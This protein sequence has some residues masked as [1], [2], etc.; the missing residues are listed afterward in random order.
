MRSHAALAALLLALPGCAHLG[1]KPVP[2][3]EAGPTG[4]DPLARTALERG[5]SSLDVSTRMRSL[6][7]LLRCVPTA[8]LQGLALRAFYDPSA[9]VRRRAVEALGARRPEPETTALL[10]TALARPELG[11]ATRARA[12]ELLLERGQPDLSAQLSAAWRALPR[13]WESVPLALVALRA[14]DAEAEA[15]VAAALREGLFPQEAGFF[16]TVGESGH[17]GLAGALREA[18]PLVEEDL[19]APLGLALLLLGDADGETLLTAALRGDDELAAMEA[20][21]VLRTSDDPSAR[22]LLAQTRG[23]R[24]IAGVYADLLAVGDGGAPLA[25]AVSALSDADPARRCLGLEAIGR[26]LAA[27]PLGEGLKRT[28]REA[29]DL[30]LSALED[31]EGEVRACAARA[32]PDLARPA[33]RALLEPLVAAQDPDAEAEALQ[34][35]AAAALI[36]LRRGG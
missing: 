11:S 19:Q 36:A 8:E 30:A 29:H 15:V 33:D 9:W 27:V 26:R 32:L 23:A 18:R 2:G 28:E 20:I 7:L 22:T 35:E 14:G 25:L 17:A 10:E 24:G 5:A 1:G 21:D 31:P 12:G 6:D 4:L 13:G 3:P 16:V 34:I